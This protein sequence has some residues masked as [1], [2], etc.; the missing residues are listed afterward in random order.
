MGREDAVVEVR[1][2]D[3]DLSLHAMMRRWPSTTGVFLRRRMLCPVCPFTS[4]YTL[5]EACDRH[6]LRLDDMLSDLRA[7]QD[8]GA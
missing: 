8:D 3:P 1:I 7:A 4:F 6:G 5:A 2:D